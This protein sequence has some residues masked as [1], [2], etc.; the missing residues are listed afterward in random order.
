MQRSFKLAACFLLLAT[1]GVSVAAEPLT[2]GF[3]TAEDLAVLTTSGDVSVD[4]QKD[5]TDGAGGALRVGPGG[6][7]SWRF[8]PEPVSATLTL[9][10]YEDGAAPTDPK[11]PGAGAHW[12]F[13]DSNGIVLSAGA[14][15]ASYL[16]GATTYAA[17]DFILD[18]TERPWQRVTYLGG[19]RA[20]RWRRWIFTLD[21]DTG[22]TIMSDNG[23][24]GAVHNPTFNWNKSR[25]KD[26][27]EIVIFGDQTDAGQVLWVD[28]ITVEPGPPMRAMPHWPP[29]PPADMVVVPPPAE[30]TATPYAPWTNGPGNDPDYF[31]IAVWLQQP[32]N[33]A[34]YKA[35]G[36]NL[37][38]GLHNGPTVAQLNALKA[39][40][41]P[42]ICTQNDTGL[43]MADEVPIIGW[44]QGDEPDNAH[45]FD[46]YW[47]SDV[48]L[49]KEAWPE[50]PAFQNLGPDRPYTG[51]G[52]PIPPRWVVRDYQ[53]LKTADP[54]RPV[55]LNLGQ[56]V[57]W[58]PYVGRGERTGH[59]EDYPEYMKGCDIASF[60]IYPVVHGDSAVDGNLWYV[61]RGVS[62]L[63]QW[64]ADTPAAG[65]IIWN[66]IECTH[67]SN[68][69]KKATPAQVR[70]EVWMSIIHGSRGLVYFVHQFEPSFVEAALLRDPEMLA[71]V[72][73]INQRIHSLAPVINS[74]TLVDAVAVESSNPLVPIHTMVKKQGSTRYLFATS[75]YQQATEGTFTIA[76]MQ[77]GEA[78]VLDENRIVV[79]E[80]GILQDSFD[81]HA[82]HLYK[83]RSHTQDTR[84]ADPI[85]L[86]ISSGL[87]YDGYISTAEHA[88]AHS[89]NPPENWTDP[90]PIGS[91]MV[92]N[93][94]GE[95]SFSNWNYGNNIFT[96]QHQVSES[97]VGLPDDGVITS[98]DWTYQL[99][100]DLDAEPEGGWSNP[101]YAAPTNPKGLL[102]LKPNVIYV[103]KVHGDTDPEY[104][105]AE[106]IL[107][108]E[109]Q[110]CYAELNMLFF[111][112]IASNYPPA[113]V[114][115]VYADDPDEPVVIWEGHP[116]RPDRD[117]SPDIDWYPSHQNFEIAFVV[118]RVFS[119]AGNYN[120]VGSTIS[121]VRIFQLKEAMKLN[122]RRVLKS[123]KFDLVS[124]KYAASDF[125]ILA[126]AARPLPP[127]AVTVIIIR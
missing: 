46:S 82:T 47:N 25:L 37:Y 110:D 79:I 63:R 38:L 118:S 48:E 84:K 94:F 39:A 36:I 10:I 24:G 7:V 32:G 90:T 107:P 43:A 11:S 5:R 104:A 45:K 99:I 88:E 42:V 19:S 117:P 4:M 30:Q 22:L 27:L 85:P 113:S 103:R 16:S 101:E 123:I 2:L 119:N 14:L 106:V 66:C 60:D 49:L 95:H 28:D 77:D 111:G 109:Q 1:F 86:D 57:A 13:K 78:E 41:M 91:R 127:P 96:W 105:H 89:Y 74:P 72:T 121:N 44:L 120:P 73:A 115:A 70:S 125:V 61:A 75:M 102:P 9:W 64:A 59:L 68:A 20:V 50:I 29:S 124:K 65:Q 92:K 56:G 80:N 15:Y 112:G 33:A 58:E 83:I 55:F 8:T 34:A 76:G 87:N 12:G 40:G 126:M 21:P 31:P 71:G 108:A 97:D 26:A 53:A 122:Q 116:Q 69:D 98:G 18:S 35:A 67:I 100:T 62:R 17:A 114:S 54:T 3:N 23:Q 81:P 6:V 93:V 52:P 51:Y